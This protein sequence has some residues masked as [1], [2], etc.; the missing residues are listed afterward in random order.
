MDTINRPLSTPVN[1][2][3]YSVIE[4]LI[5]IL[6][7]GMQ[8]QIRHPIWRHNFLSFGENSCRKVYLSWQGYMVVC[9]LN[10]INFYYENTLMNVKLF[11]DVLS[12]L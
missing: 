12:T 9:Q 8:I 4:K 2:S 6:P 1:E 5:T 10:C 3:N 7:D 11:F